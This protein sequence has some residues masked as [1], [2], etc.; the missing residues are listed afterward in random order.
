M[1]LFRR[2]ECHLPECR[3]LLTN[4]AM[5]LVTKCRQLYGSSHYDT[6]LPNSMSARNAA[7]YR[8]LVIMT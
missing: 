1:V 3:Y 8:A 2:T 5:L 7:W 4:D 6:M